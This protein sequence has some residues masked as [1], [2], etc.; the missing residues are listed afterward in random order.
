MLSESGSHIE[1]RSF[2]SKQPQPFVTIF[3]QQPIV[4][5]FSSIQY[6]YKHKISVEKK[7][8]FLIIVAKFSYLWNSINGFWMRKYFSPFFFPSLILPYSF[9]VEKPL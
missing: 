4:Y 8:L 1:E 9:W 2:Q 3:R 7:K 6:S 5:D